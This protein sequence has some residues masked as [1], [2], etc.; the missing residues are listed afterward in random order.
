MYALTPKD[1]KDRTGRTEFADIARRPS[2]TAVVLNWNGRERILETISA[3]YKSVYPFKEILM[4][5]NGSN[6]GSLEAV[7]DNFPRVK[8]L[9][10]K[11][12]LGVSEGRNV[13]IRRAVAAG[14]EYVFHIDNDIEVQPETVGELVRTAEERRDVG[15]VGTI[16]YFKSDPTLIQN[17]GG[18]ICYR[19][20]ILLPIG[21]MERDRGQFTGPIEIDMVAGGAMLTRRAVFEQV[22]YFDE[23]YIGYGLEDTDFCVRVRRAGWKLLCNPRAKTFHDFQLTH[24]YNYRRK[25]LESRNAVCFLRKYGRSIDWAKYLFFSIGGLPYAFVREAFRGNLGGVVGKAQGLF[26]SIMRRDDR[27]IEV[28]QSRD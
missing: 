7:R 25:Y 5:D 22:G 21:W 2:V 15:I 26:D 24:K 14:V 18:H 12:N 6:D 10:Q 19:Q 13:G 20:H 9:P 8:I 27:A 17:L 16:M 4:V 3:L 23:G 28:F 11:A 1:V